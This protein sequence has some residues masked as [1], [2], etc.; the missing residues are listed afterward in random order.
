MNS[1]KIFDWLVVIAVAVGL[2]M[3]PMAGWANGSPDLPAIADETM[4]MMADNMPCCP[5][6]Q[7]QK[8]Q[9]CGY[10]SL[11]APCMFNFSLPGPEAALLVDRQASRSAFALPD[12]LL[13]DGLGEHPPDHPP[14]SIV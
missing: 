13:I 9:D 10:C 4:Q 7:E 1:Q 3:A 2:L 8:A 12:D 14:R 6:R 11:L 5:D